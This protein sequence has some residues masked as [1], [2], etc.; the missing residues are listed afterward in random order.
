MRSQLFVDTAADNVRVTTKL[1]AHGYNRS[2]LAQEYAIANE[3]QQ[4]SGQMC[5]KT[6]MSLI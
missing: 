6:T 2:H 4:N 1:K 5:L 3:S